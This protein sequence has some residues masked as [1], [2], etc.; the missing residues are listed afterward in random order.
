MQWIILLLLVTVKLEAS[1]CYFETYRFESKGDMPSVRSHSNEF[2]VDFPDGTTLLSAPYVRTLAQPLTSLN[3][4]WGIRYVW[5]LSDN[6]VFNIKK[7]IKNNQLKIVF[8]TSEC[9]IARKKIVVLD[10]GHGGKDTGAISSLN[11]PEKKLTL[12]YAKALKNYIQK[13]SSYEVYLTRRDD[14]FLSLRERIQIAESAQADLLISVHADAFKSNMAQ[15]S[16]VYAL[17]LNGVNSDSTK[18]LSDMSSNSSSMLKESLLHQRKLLGLLYDIKQTRTLLKSIHAGHAIRG[19]IRKNNLPVHGK[20]VEQAGFVVLSS[21]SVPSVLV[22]LG[23][24][25]SQQ[26]AQRLQS[27]IGRKQ[28]VQAIGDAIIEYLASIVEPINT[29]SKP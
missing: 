23:Y 25:S 2:S 26:D 22:E 18:Y 21:A 12:L 11:Y 28:L 1:N 19:S 16:S 13:N 29:E 7:N 10:P 27:S 14:R 8:T 20:K 6:T 4:S 24:L 15:G 5:R 17:S 3:G 9:A